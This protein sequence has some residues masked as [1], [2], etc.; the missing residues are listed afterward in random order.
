MKKIIIQKVAE[1]S[2]GSYSLTLGLDD[3]G[4]LVYKDLPDENYG[5]T[6]HEM[7]RVSLLEYENNERAF[8]IRLNLHY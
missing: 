3:I 5:T 2:V 4:I 7:A 8:S 6:I 1:G